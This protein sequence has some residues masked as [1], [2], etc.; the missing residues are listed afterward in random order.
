MN[1]SCDTMWISGTGENW[2][3]YRDGGEYLYVK[4]VYYGRNGQKVYTG[5]SGWLDR[6]DIVRDFDYMNTRGN[7]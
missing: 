6:S 7:F 4:Q 1:V 2:T 5:L 3:T